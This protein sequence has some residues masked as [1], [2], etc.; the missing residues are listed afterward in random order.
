MK[1]VCLDG[2]TLNPGD[3]SWAPIEQLGELTVYDRTPPEHVVARA[4]D[5]EIVLTNKTPLD[6]ALA[7]LPK[8]RYIGVLATGYN[9][10]NVQDARERAILVTHVPT[11]GTDSVAQFTFALLLELCHRVG[12]HG[13]LVVEG[14]WSDCPDFC[15]WRTPQVELAGKTLGVIGA[16]RIGRRVIELALA[17][18]M[19]VL[20]ADEERNRALPAGARWAEL[21]EIFAAAD[22]VSLHVPLTPQTDKLV[23]A[24]RLATMKP[25]AFL[26]NTSRGAVVNERALRD[27][28]DRG[29]I[30]GAALDVL[31]VEP[32]PP[33]HPLIGAPRCIVTPH[34]AWSSREAR[35]RLMDAVVENLRAFLAGRPINVVDP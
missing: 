9:V 11:Y 2:K 30:A 24:R 23:N 21:D 1:I 12:L 7:E 10:V 20:A 15:F 14:Q 35:T 5:A 13:G 17:F 25:T 26:I 19:E 34:V 31:S 33:D 29:R 16:G 28:L 32:P 8:L 6:R 22:A 18:G 27:A 4:A 3:L